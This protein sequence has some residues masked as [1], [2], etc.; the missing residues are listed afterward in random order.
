MT[1][2]PS[3]VQRNVKGGAGEGYYFGDAAPRLCARDCAWVFLLSMIILMPTVTPWL[4]KRLEG[5]DGRFAQ[6]IL[7]PAVTVLYLQ[8][9]TI[10]SPHPGSKTSLYASLGVKMASMEEVDFRRQKIPKTGL[11]TSENGVQEVC[12]AWSRV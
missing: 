2:N 3:T 9:I 11:P 7:T 5:L 8:S 4:R 12:L 6:P 10:V 1:A